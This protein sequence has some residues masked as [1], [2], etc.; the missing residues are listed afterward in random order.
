M[1]FDV[2]VCIMHKK[3]NAKEKLKKKR[4]QQKTVLTGFEPTST[5]KRGFLVYMYSKNE[6]S[7]Y[8]AIESLEYYT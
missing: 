1:T 8:C 5:K 7:T 3:L 4:Q 6:R 2:Y